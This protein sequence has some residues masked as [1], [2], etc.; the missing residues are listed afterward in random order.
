MP[1]QPINAFPAR[2]RRARI[3][4]VLERKAAFLDHAAAVGVP[5]PVADLMDATSIKAEADDLAY[6]LARQ[7]A[8]DLGRVARQSAAEMSRVAIGAISDVRA[9]AEQS[10]D[11]A[12]VYA[13]VS[14][15][16]RRPASPAAAPTTPTAVQPTIRPDGTVTLSWTGPTAGS[17]FRVQRALTDAQ[18]QT[19]EYTELP[20]AATRPAAVGT[21]PPGTRAASYRLKA[22]RHG[23]ESPWS[24]PTTL[25]VT[26]DEAPSSPLRLAA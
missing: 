11:P 14:V 17:S 5:Q 6:E 24:F 8:V 19:G 4:W 9:F 18:G 21:L 3:Q 20:P 15:A 12:A 10:D 1:V 13:L 7:R 22:L 23:Q 25:Q 16:P 26:T 2:N